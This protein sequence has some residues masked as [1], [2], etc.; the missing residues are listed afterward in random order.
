MCTANTRAIMGCLLGSINWMLNVR[1]FLHL[2]QIRQ[3]PFVSQLGNPDQRVS[4]SNQGSSYAGCW[5]P[6][7]SAGRKE[8]VIQL[9]SVRPTFTPYTIAFSIRFESHFHRRSWATDY[10][11][12]CLLTRSGEF[13]S[14]AP[15][16]L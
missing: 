14:V 8:R 13:S 9:S 6:L 12:S 2:K 16:Q 7:R 3:A 10:S 15:P 5:L 11:L 4:V 1:L